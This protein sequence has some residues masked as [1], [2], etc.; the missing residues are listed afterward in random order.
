M[1][2][3]ARNTGTHFRFDNDKGAWEGKMR[4]KVINGNI[5]EFKEFVTQVAT[6]LELLAWI[7]DILSGL[8]AAPDTTVAGAP[9]AA[10]VSAALAAI[11]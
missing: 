7:S 5:V 2:I 9:D 6:L 3:L 8:A 10:E 11:S 1:A 4:L